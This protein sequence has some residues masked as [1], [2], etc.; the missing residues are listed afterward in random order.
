MSSLLHGLSLAAVS[1]GYPQ[2]GHELLVVMASL[3]QSMGSAVC[4]LQ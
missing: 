4:G 3:L 1:G 2:V